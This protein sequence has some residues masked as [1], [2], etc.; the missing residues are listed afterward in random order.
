MAILAS[1]TAPGFSSCEM[2][3]ILHATLKSVW[4]CQP[5]SYDTPLIYFPS[6]ISP[7][8]VTVVTA[9]CSG[10][11]GKYSLISLREQRANVSALSIPTALQISSTV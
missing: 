11:A 8:G 9:R 1:D 6:I 3:V 10:T 2:G 5:N 4:K 7:M